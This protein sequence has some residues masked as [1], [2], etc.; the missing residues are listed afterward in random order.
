MPNR[1]DE[2]DQAATMQM[3]RE[4]CAAHGC[5]LPES[6]TITY[7]DWCQEKPGPDGIISL[8]IL[9]D[10][11]AV[12]SDAGST[13]PYVDIDEMISQA[14]DGAVQLVFVNGAWINQGHDFLS[15]EENRGLYVFRAMIQEAVNNQ[16]YK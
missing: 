14:D 7:A 9:S 5:D 4:A 15:T 16:S 10:G 8:Y 1:I 6:A 2:T 12:L 3:I 13:T 11:T